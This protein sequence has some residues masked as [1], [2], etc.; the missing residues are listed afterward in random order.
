MITVPDLLELYLGPVQS[1]KKVAQ[2]EKINIKKEYV[3]Q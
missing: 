1:E 3:K 2:V